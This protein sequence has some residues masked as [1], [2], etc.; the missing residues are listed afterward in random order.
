VGFGH[1]DTP[2]HSQLGDAQGKAI[3]NVLEQAA[4]RGLLATATGWVASAAL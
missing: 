3:E 2:A 1:F 4:P